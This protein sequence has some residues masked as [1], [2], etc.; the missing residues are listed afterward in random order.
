[1]NMNAYWLL[2]MAYRKK[3]PGMREGQILFN[4][5]AGLRP[6]MASFVTGKE[7]DPFYDDDRI[8]QFIDF[9]SRLP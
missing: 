1:M 8:P 2:V 6:H 5:F 9:I 3:H 4:V 7:F